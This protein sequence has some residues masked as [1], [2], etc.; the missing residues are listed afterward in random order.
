MVYPEDGIDGVILRI[1]TID[2]G[3]A[4]AA[5]IRVNAMEDIFGLP[6]GAYTVSQDSAWEDGSA[7]PEPMEYVNLMT[8]PRYFAENA[9]DITAAEYPDVTT[10]IVAASSDLDTSGFTLY[11]VE[12]APNG[13]STPV[14]IGHRSVVGR[15]VLSST[16]PAAYK[17][18][19]DS[20][21]LTGFT[22]PTYTYANC[23]VLIGEGGDT[24]TEIALI[25]E[26]SDT[27]IVLHRGLLDTVPRD[28]PADTPL[29][30][31]PGDLSMSDE[32]VRAGG[33]T[34]EYK[35]LTETSLGVLPFADAPIESVTL[36][37]RPWLPNRPGNVKIGG[38]AFGSVQMGT[39]TTIPIT[40]ANRNRLME[41]TEV[42]KWADGNVTPE[43]GQ[44][45]RVTVMKTDRTVLTTHDGLTGTSFDLPATSFVGQATGIVRLTAMRD[46]LE[47][48]QGHEITVTLEPQGWGTSWG[49]FWGG[50]AGGSWT[51]IDPE[52]PPPE[53]DPTPTDPWE[54]P[55]SGGGPGS[56]GWNPYEQED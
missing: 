55:P 36:T 13:Q 27:G 9:I 14:N 37:E 39:A 51:P 5:T 44:T 35:I 23:F 4:G 31:F 45:T 3:K 38:V 29:W 46:G 28:W 8:T 12:P 16:L 48:L 10:M 56:P 7:I 42:V 47:S 52:T 2:Y 17:S 26:A 15:A 30:F 54:Q 11:T 6:V 25:S 40:W 34:A 20:T 43:A 19:I 49:S 1:G 33:E 24:A 32:S 53:P 41:P 22:G 18:S 21:N 50:A